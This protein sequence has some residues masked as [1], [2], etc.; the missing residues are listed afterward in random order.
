MQPNYKKILITGAGGFIASRTAA[1]LLDAGNNITGVDNL[2][3]SCDPRLKKHRL[4]SL[5]GRRGKFQ[6]YRADV[7][8]LTALRKIFGKH[9]PDAVI[10]LAARAGVRYSLENP[11]IYVSTNVSGTLNVLELCR[12][13]GARK[14]VF[15][16]TSSLYAAEPAPFREEYPVNKPISPYAAT[17]KAAETMCYT[18]HYLHGLDVTI[19][20]YF[21]VY[22]PAGRPDMS[23]FRFI[24]QIRRGKTVSIYGDGRQERDFTF[25]DDIARGTVMGLKKVGFRVI[26]LGGGK[27]Y[28]LSRLV[29]LIEKNTG[30]KAKIRYC[31]AS[32]TD[33]KNTWADNS[34]ARR[35]LGWRPEVSL[36]EGVKRTVAWHRE[37][38]RF[39]ETIPLV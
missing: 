30:R 32:K 25:I 14:L 6:F 20:R 11:F 12:E 22:G 34:T 7:S 8:D 37:N 38:E 35:I 16:S 21:T 36:E 39:V 26:N 10:H 28:P 29:R 15:A 17:K 24:E 18:Y 1:L 2:N 13:F 27:R 19:L 5:Q 23:Y 33:M 4:K 3:D 9:R 31:P